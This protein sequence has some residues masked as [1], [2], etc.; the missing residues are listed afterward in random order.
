MTE[1]SDEIRDEIE[2]EITKS[3]IGGL[4]DGRATLTVRISKVSSYTLGYTLQPMVKL[5]KTRP[6]SIQT[7]DDWAAKNGIYAEVKETETGYTIDINR[8][9]DIARFLEQLYPYVQDKMEAFEIMLGDVLPAMERG[10]HYES[11]ESF[12]SIVEDVERIRQLTE[13]KGASK[14]TAEYFRDEWDL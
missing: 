8:Q 12:V 6:F 14:Y 4:V 7:V 5:S 3:Y 10:D 1:L 9:R 2:R 11:K 13:G